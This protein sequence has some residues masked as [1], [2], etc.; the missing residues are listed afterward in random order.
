MKR[1]IYYER[2]CP[3]VCLLHSPVTPKRFKISICALDRTSLSTF[4]TLGQ[5]VAEFLII[6]H[7]F[8][9][10]FWEQVNVPPSSV[11]RGPNYIKLADDTDQ[12]SAHPMYFYSASTLLAMQT[13]VIAGVILSVRLSVRHVPV[14]CPD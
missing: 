12:S 7:I 1:G 6:Q 3:S 13:A 10:V 5:C 4:S 11:S 14:L 2:V 8:P 9:V